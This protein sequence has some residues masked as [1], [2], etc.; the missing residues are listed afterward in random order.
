MGLENFADSIPAPDGG[1]N[2][3]FPDLSGAVQPSGEG[4][5]AHTVQRMGDEEQEDFFVA[6]ICAVPESG[7]SNEFAFRIGF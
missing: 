6:E 4:E 2:G 7:F 3:Q 5:G 1:G